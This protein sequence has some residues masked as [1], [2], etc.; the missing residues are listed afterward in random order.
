SA[1]VAPA[2]VTDA[3]GLLDL[4]PTF[5]DIAGVE[6]PSWVQGEALP[7]R[8]GEGRDYVLTEWDSQFRQCGM[9]IRTIYR[10]GFICTAYERSTND[11]LFGRAEREIEIPYEGTEGELYKVDD[12]PYQW[13]NLWDD[14]GYASVRRELVTSLYD[15]LP[16]E[17]EPKLYPEAP[18]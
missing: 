17:R 11:G 18:T 15:E 13:Q 6:H 9:H 2:S 14:A 8:D 3:V 16:S 10:D 7:V 4:A 12:D 1:G 5:C